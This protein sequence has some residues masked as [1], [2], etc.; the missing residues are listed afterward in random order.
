MAFKSRLQYIV[1]FLLISLYSFQGFS[2]VPFIKFSERTYNKLNEHP[3][4]FYF[5]KTY[6]EVK[7]NTSL[8]PVEINIPGNWADEGFPR[9]GYGTYVFK[10][11]HNQLLDSRLSL[12]LYTIAC[13][14]QLFVNGKLLRETGIFSIDANHAKPDFHPY[15]ISFEVETDTVEIA[16]QVS[17]FQYRNG[18][19]WFTPSIGLPQIME[20]SDNRNSIVEAFLFGSLF[21]LF[22]YF[23]SFYYTKTSDKTSLYFALTCLFAAIRIGSTGEILLR[24]ISIGFPW[25]VIVKL[26]YIS[27][28]LML[29]FGFLYLRCLFPRD[30][31]SSIFKGI[32]VIQ[33]AACFLFLFLPVFYASFAI[34]YYLIFCGLLL[35]YMLNLVVKINLVKRPYAMEVGLA[36]FLVIVAGVNDIFYSQA[37]IKTFYAMPLGILIY[38]IIQAMVITRLFSNTFTKVELLSNELLNINKNQQEIIEKRTAELNQNTVAL[39]QSNQIKDKVFSIIAHDLR[40]PIKSLSTVLAWVAEDDLTYEELKKSLSN[41]SKNVDTLN[42]TLENLLQWSRSQL[43]G[44][45]SEP[46]LIDIRRPIQEMMDLFKIQLGEKSLVLKYDNSQR[47]A[48]FIDKHHLNLLFR[49]LLSNAI[50]FSH[51]GSAIEIVAK[52]ISNNQTL[53][54]IIDSGIGMNQEALDKVFSSTDHYSTYGTKNERGTGLGLLLCKEYIENGGGKIWIESKE[55][56][57]TKISFVLPNISE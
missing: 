33:I 24:Q 53:I 57:G 35:A 36:T 9:T 2:A 7:E 10:F 52:D 25:E 11:T 40:A 54:E 42:L 15:L 5:E 45:K 43:N 39:E 13:S 20:I 23:L 14:H 56:K 18:G 29:L 19:L 27:L 8:V 44:V 41:I 30:F 49:N 31:N 1:F 21:L 28:V 50:K 16:I 47:H 55:G 26:E 51:A 12:K 6:Q 17:N 38:A 34:P 22:S 46:E 32:Q 48:V 3:W 4:Q 37:V